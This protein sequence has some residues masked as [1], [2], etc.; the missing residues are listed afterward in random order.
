MGA[1]IIESW[2]R[3]A[4]RGVFHLT[5]PGPNRLIPKCFPTSNIGENSFWEGRFFRRLSENVYYAESGL[6]S[7]RKAG[8]GHLKVLGEGFGE[9]PSFKKVLPNIT[10]LA[11]HWSQER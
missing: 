9:K 7:L 3:P 1:W 11:A 2:N 8:F 6:F 4:G 10:S 5:A